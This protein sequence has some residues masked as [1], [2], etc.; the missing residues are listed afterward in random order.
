LLLVVNIL[1]NYT[2]L[3]LYCIFRS[4]SN[5]SSNATSRDANGAILS[6][7]VGSDNEGCRREKTTHELNG[8]KY[9][10]E[11]RFCPGAP[12]QT[13][14]TLVNLNREELPTFL[15]HW[16]PTNKQEQPTPIADTSTVKN[17][18]IFDKFFGPL[19]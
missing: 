15:Q 3:I 1:F 10:L 9:V 7:S 17:P 18:E 5:F 16:Q 12:E 2:F 14:E 11:K 6:Q 4:W 13:T 8:K 19:K